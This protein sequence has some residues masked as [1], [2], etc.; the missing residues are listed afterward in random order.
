MYIYTYYILYLYT[1][2]IYV[3]IYASYLVVGLVFLGVLHVASLQEGGRGSFVIVI[4]NPFCVGVQ[5]ILCLEAA[6]TMADWE[7]KKPPQSQDPL[8]PPVR[9]MRG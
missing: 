1:I 6:E 2:Y 8:N 3:Y 4:C 9:G 7:S 5:G